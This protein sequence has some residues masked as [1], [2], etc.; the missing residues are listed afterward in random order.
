MLTINLRITRK[1][2]TKNI[3]PTKIAKEE[4]TKNKT[5]IKVN[6]K[7]V[8]NYKNNKNILKNIKKYKIKSDKIKSSK[9]KI[10][11]KLIEGTRSKRIQK[12]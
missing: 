5:N 9:I 11:V 10:I 8:K 2:I 4:E 7:N 1:K 12:N 3:K 6:P